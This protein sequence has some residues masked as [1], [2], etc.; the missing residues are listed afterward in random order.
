[1]HVLCVT[2]QVSACECVTE[3]VLC[4]CVCVCMHEMMGYIRH[5]SAAKD[6]RPSTGQ[7][8]PHKSLEWSTRHNTE[9]ELTGASV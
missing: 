3:L 9:I 4:V 5:S 6:S 2:E 1:M 8:A 7:C